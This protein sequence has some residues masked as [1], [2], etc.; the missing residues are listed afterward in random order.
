MSRSASATGTTDELDALIA[1]LDAER[2]DLADKR[3]Q[4][5]ALTETIAEARRRP[6]EL[7]AEY[8]AQRAEPRPSSAS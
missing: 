4:A 1:D 7:T 3:E 6:I 5:E 2:A 8:E